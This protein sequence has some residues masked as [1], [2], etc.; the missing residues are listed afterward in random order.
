VNAIG[1]FFEKKLRKKLLIVPA[2]EAV[3]WPRNR[4]SNLA[5]RRSPK[6][7]PGHKILRKILE[8]M[9]GTRSHKKQIL[10]SERAPLSIKNKLTAP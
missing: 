7:H 4:W 1:R 10:R 6:H 9:R 5:A 2:C 8:P 3:I